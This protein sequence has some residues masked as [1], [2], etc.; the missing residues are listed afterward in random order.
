MRGATDALLE[1]SDERDEPACRGLLRSAGSES[2][3][4][5]DVG[6]DAR[7]P[8]GWLQ[9][10]LL[11]D[12]GQFVARHGL[13]LH[14]KFLKLVVVVLLLT[15]VTRQ[16]SCALPGWSC[17]HDF[18][19]TDFFK[20]YWA[21]QCCDLLVIFFVGR[22]CRRRGADT[23][24]FFVM[25]LL[26]SLA[27]SAQ[28]AIPFMRVSLSLYAIMC[29]WQPMTGVWVAGEVT[30]LACITAKHVR[31]AIASKVALSWTAEAMALVVIFFLP[32]S[33]D[34]AFH[35]HHWFFAWIIA[36]LARFDPA[37]SVAT[38]A[39]MIGYYVN[40]IAIYG[41]HPVLACKDVVFLNQ[42]QGCGLIRNQT[43]GTNP[44]PIYVSP[45]PW[46]CSGD[47]ARRRSPSPILL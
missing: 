5:S 29:Q 32:N 25:S 34:S 45:N 30:L 3:A 40:G 47:Y 24:L 9:R 15:L 1:P 4:G 12:S 27:P 11:P 13:E 8:A 16:V 6:S 43:N 7:E 44:S 36:L 21:A 42:Q 10:N 37:W 46:N 35:M 26:G 39:F 14:A 17:K 31:H 19:A 33:A 20:Y 2:D 28:D 41:R 18:A 38:Q 23:P 22:M